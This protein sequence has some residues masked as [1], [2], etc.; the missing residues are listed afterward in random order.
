LL[1]D[2][3]CGSGTRKYVLGVGGHPIT[4]RTH[5]LQRQLEVEIDLA[6]DLASLIPYSKSS[7][8][9]GGELLAN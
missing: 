2:T 4:F 1:A 5:T 7:R 3:G 6:F 9:A 8:Q